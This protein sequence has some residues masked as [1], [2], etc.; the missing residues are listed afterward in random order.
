MGVVRFGTIFLYLVFFLL[1]K[2]SSLSY[3]IYSRPVNLNSE[4]TPTKPHPYNVEFDGVNLKTSEKQMAK[5][6]RSV[7]WGFK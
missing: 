3:G 6:G 2:V 5:K 4:K 7:F 1:Q